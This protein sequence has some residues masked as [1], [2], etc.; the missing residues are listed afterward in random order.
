[1]RRAV[2]VATIAFAVCAAALI[3]VLVLPTARP[4]AAA[5]D[6]SDAN[7]AFQP[8]P[9][10][11][12]PLDAELVDEHGR[13]A[14]LGR[15]FT[16]TPVILVLEYL[17]CRSLCGVT[18]RDLMDTLNRLPLAAGRDYQLVAVS[19]DPR[20]KPADAAAA[21]AKY[22]ALL[23]RGSETGLHFLT[24]PTPAVGSIADT[25]GF[26]YRYDAFLDAYIH[27]AGFVIAT[28]EGV[29]SRYVEGI[30][31]SP[32]KLVE[33]FANAE[34]D[35]SQ[36]PLARIILLCHIQGAPLG[37]YTVPVMAALTIANVAAGLTLIALF[38]AIRR[39]A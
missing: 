16:K 11:Q 34:Q 38:A 39:Q 9:G 36:G 29:V 4:V 7:L 27:P 25:I 8:H 19:I 33:A 14:T 26:H 12:L 21:R 15:Y 13:A 10:A 18:L 23:N 22:A 35:K 1:M 3:S 30:A 20:D 24:A 2:C 5:N 28:P 37:R 17:R 6:M 31:I 32:Q